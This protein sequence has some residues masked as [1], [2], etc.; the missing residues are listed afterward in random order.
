MY[1][2]ILKF[3]LNSV[4]YMNTLMI[5]VI[6]IQALRSE[7]FPFFEKLKLLKKWQL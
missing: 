6:P 4:G 7:I 2:F 3:K 5:T 1:I